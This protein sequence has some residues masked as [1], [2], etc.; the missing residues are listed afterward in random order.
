MLSTN[1]YYSAHTF[2]K[3]LGPESQAAAVFDPAAKAARQPDYMVKLSNYLYQK[4]R[5]PLD[6]GPAQGFII[7]NANKAQVQKVQNA[8]PDLPEDL[9]WWTDTHSTQPRS[10]AELRA[11]AIAGAIEFADRQNS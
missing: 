8:L 1:P 6:V 11:A 10:P 5:V 7:V 4:T 3:N 2:A 9:V